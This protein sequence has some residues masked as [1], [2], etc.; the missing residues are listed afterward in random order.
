ML[1]IYTPRLTNRLGYTLNVLLR[2]V[3]HTPFGITTD[4]QVYA[5][6]ADAK[7]CYGRRLAGGL[8][9][10]A[11]SLLFET[12]IDEQEPRPFCH[13]G[14]W[15]LF[16][17]L[18]Q[19]VAFP[20]DPL[21]ATF[22]MVSRYE[23][24]L[25]HRQD[26]HG[27]F[28]SDG[29]LAVQHGFATEPVVDQWAML[30]RGAVEQAYPGFTFGQR[31]YQ[32][33]QTVDIDTAWCYRHKGLYRTLMGLGRDLLAR[34]DLAAVRQ[35]LRV[36]AR[37]EPDP[38]D[39]FDYIIGQHRRS[40]D[41][42]LLFFA[43]LADY[44]LYDKPANYHQSHTRQLLQHLGDYAKM[45]IH[46]SYNS[47]DNPRL[48]DVET[49]RLQQILHRHI[50]RSR[51]HFLRLRL[52]QSYRALLH[53]GLRH[54]YTMGFA[55]TAGF[56][57]GISSPYPFYD[58]ERDF[59]TELTIHPFCAMDTALKSHMGLDP[60]QA[61]DLYRKLI[62]SVR[63]VDGTYCAI[64]HNQNLSAYDGWQQWRGVYEQTLEW[65]RP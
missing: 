46:P 62:D 53:A 36:L 13:D 22:Y 59:E 15:M 7:L 42:H 57:A 10:K 56:R 39:T 23:E 60:G 33:V 31:R 19:G 29:H 16:P 40:P 49:D 61:L 6:H 5:R 65:A 14:Q 25:P 37:R 38:F 47:L 35:R 41:S 44:D 27:R 2:D 4:E 26:A 11:A 32:M 18:G 48:V 21:A 24:Y 63:R 55:D 51:Y 28:Q 1:L 45:G 17:V 52:P 43:L 9:V 54:D 34:R 20:F 3:L 8:Y 12:S 58:L 50:V 64:I 30:L